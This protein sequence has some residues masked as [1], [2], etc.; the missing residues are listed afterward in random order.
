MGWS[1]GG[2]W[3]DDGWSKPSAG[4]GGSSTRWDNDAALYDSGNY[5]NVAFTSGDLSFAVVS[6]GVGRS[7]RGNTPFSGTSEYFD[8]VGSGATVDAGLVNTSASMTEELYSQADGTQIFAD[9]RVYNGFS[10]Y[11]DWGGT[12]TSG[13]HVRI[14]VNSVAR[15]FTVAVNGGSPSAAIAILIS[16]AILPAAV[17]KDGGTVVGDFT[18]LP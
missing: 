1:S 9:G 15:T 11:D 17:V 10:H 13:D 16:G 4:G 8:I 2:S 12:W 14:R 5:A 3:G 6:G 18:G 7:V